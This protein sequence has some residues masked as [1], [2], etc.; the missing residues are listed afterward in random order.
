MDSKILDGKTTK[1]N[2][3]LKRNKTSEVK[4]VSFKVNVLNQGTEL[5]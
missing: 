5:Y 2:I 4:L 1:A 3:R